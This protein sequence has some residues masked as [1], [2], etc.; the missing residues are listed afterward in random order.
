VESREYRPPWWY[1]GRHLQTVWASLFRRPEPPPLRRQRLSTPDGDFVDVDWIA[2]APAARA[3]LILILHGLEGSSRSHYALGLLR[4]VADRGWDGAVLHFRTCSGE[5]NRSLR[6][7]HSGD[8]GDLDWLVQRLT[9]ERPDRRIGVIGV[10]L[11][12]NV[13]L[14]WLGERGDAL[15]AGVR[16]A[17]AISVPFDLAAAAA[18]LDRGF[19]RRLYTEHFLQT[20][21]VKVWA[22]AAMYRDLMDL[23]AIARART[24]R[25]WDRF[26]TAPL[27]G[28][29]D[30]RDY[31]ER[32][33]SGPVLTAIR[34]PCLL[35]NALN[36]PFV[37]AASLP[38]AAVR[39]SRWLEA[40]FVP[41]GG[42][43]G[44][45]EGPRGERSWA[46]RRALAFLA[47]HLASAPLASSS[48][49]FW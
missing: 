7:Y 35:I 49:P 18:V 29:A 12:G 24:F 28:F 40:A 9:A 41:E 45:V 5:L 34:R 44:F 23:A 39:G 17:V 1:R 31:W 3:P 38:R 8:T 20:M 36:D 43:A 21:R 26:V 37:P 48:A 22:K 2:A 46:E 11:G 16:A 30:E 15:A 33:S 4:E 42:H 47:G 13:M 25:E 14:R 10:S 19:R 32:C 27:Y 6:L